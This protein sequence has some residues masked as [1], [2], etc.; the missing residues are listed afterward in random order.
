MMRGL[1]PFLGLIAL[2]TQPALAQGV[3]DPPNY[4]LTAG[5]SWQKTPTIQP[6]SRPAAIRNTTGSLHSGVAVQ[7]VYKDGKLVAVPRY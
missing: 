1:L 3:K 5:Q 4:K 2:L 7:G 6:I